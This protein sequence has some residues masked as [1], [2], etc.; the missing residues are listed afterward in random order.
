MSQLPVYSVWGD[1]KIL[2]QR[3]ADELAQANASA[4]VL[5]DENEMLRQRIKA[6]EAHEG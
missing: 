2:M 6:L 5:R 1:V 4:A 3:A